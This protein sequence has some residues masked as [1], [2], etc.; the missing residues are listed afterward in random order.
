MEKER[1]NRIPFLLVQVENKA[2]KI[3]TEV[4]RKSTHKYQHINFASH[5]ILVQIGVIICLRDRAEKICNEEHVRTEKQ[6]LDRVFQTNGYPNGLVHKELYRRRQPQPTT[7][8]TGEGHTGGEAKDDLPPLPTAHFGTYPAS[9]WMDWGEDNIQVLL[10]CMRVP[11]EGEESPTGANEERSGV[12]CTGY[13]KRRVLEAIKIQSHAK[14]TN[15]DCGLNYTQSRLH[16][17]FLT[18][19]NISWSMHNYL[20]VYVYADVFVVA[21]NS[22]ISIRKIA[23][24]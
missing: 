17:F 19:I 24:L 7:T 9:L 20:N 13:W 4:Y 14:T 11:D 1:E 10:Q 22:S 21:T 6:H 15:L 5:P 12:K 16:S 2:G 3:S 8:S 23:C 18:I